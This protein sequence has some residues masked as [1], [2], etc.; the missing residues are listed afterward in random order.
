MP[1]RLREGRTG[2]LSWQSCAAR[3]ECFNYRKAYTL[4][5]YYRDTRC[6]FSRTMSPRARCNGRETMLKRTLI[7]SVVAMAALSVT[8]ASNVASAA[9]FADPLAIK[10]I[11]GTDVETVGWHGGHGWGG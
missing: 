3:A 4:R 9:P 11:A 10:N 8:A 2:K 1:R 5:R 7:L 6:D